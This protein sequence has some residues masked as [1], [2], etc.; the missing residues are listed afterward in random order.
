MNLRELREL[1]VDFAGG[2]GGDYVMVTA[3]AVTYGT[4]RG[5]AAEKNLHV[6]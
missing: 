6:M 4:M 5:R 3:A 1:Q 2:L